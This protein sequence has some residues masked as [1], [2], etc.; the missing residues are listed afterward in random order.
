MLDFIKDI[1]EYNISSMICDIEEDIRD[2]NNYEYDFSFGSDGDI[3]NTIYKILEK[4]D[5]NN[6][7]LIHD[8]GGYWC[9]CL[10]EEPFNE[11][12]ESKYTEEE[13][14]NLVKEHHL[15]IKSGKDL[16]L[17]LYF[18]NNSKSPLYRFFLKHK[19]GYGGNIAYSITAGLNK[20]WKAIQ[21]EL[22]NNADDYGKF[23]QG[24]YCNTCECMMYD[25][26]GICPDCKSE[27]EYK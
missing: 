3:C 25:D 11:I 8:F 26:S 2:R 7:D 1:K 21:K 16:E 10:T 24:G 19:D 12:C 27:L 6:L 22:R 23:T 9:T 4:I 5:F 15:R 14:F 13:F 20:L 17:V 18:K